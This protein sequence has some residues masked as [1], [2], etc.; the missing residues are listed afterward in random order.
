MPVRPG[1]PGREDADSA[2]TTILDC[3]MV[4]TADDSPRV[5]RPGAPRGEHRPQ[6]QAL[7]LTNHSRMTPM[8]I[9]RIGRFTSAVLLR[10]S[11]GLPVPLSAE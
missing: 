2:L 11:A 6:V 8:T 10:F 7:Y 9:Q 1:R 5:S 3:V 4:K